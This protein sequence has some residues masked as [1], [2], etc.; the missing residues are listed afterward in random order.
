MKVGDLVIVNTPAHSPGQDLHA[1]FSC[2]GMIVDKKVFRENDGIDV[3]NRTWWYVLRSDTGTVEK[4][5]EDWMTAGK[6]GSW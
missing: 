1:K 5:H 2:H 3:K 4:F 6:N